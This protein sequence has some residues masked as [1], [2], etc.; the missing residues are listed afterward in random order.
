MLLVWTFHNPLADGGRPEMSDEVWND[1]QG[2]F[3]TVISALAARVR[4]GRR[5]AAYRFNN[6][7]HSCGAVVLHGQKYLT[8]LSVLV[9]AVRYLRPRVGRRPGL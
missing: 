8:L 1:G 3:A 4:A 6:L 9:V 7:V 5:L 2:A